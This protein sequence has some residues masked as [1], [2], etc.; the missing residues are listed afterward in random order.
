MIDQN[1]FFDVPELK[2]NPI[3]Q[4]VISVF[5]KNGDGK[6]SFYEFI[7]GLSVLTDSAN[8]EEKIKFAFQVYDSNND[9]FISNGDLFNA[10]KLLV[11]DNLTDIQLQQ[12]VD[13]TI[14]EA[15]KDQDGKLSYEEFSEF[16]QDMKINEFF[17]MKL[18]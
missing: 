6:V 13:R 1:E 7:L 17:S 18:F 12:V 5:D 4:R 8:P 14:I 15:D 2:E 11:G 16:V 9:G 10:M 3:V